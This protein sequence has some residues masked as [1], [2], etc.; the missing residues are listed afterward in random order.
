[1]FVK[2]NWNEYTNRSFNS[3]LLVLLVNSGEGTFWEKVTAGKMERSSVLSLYISALLS[4][5]CQRR[6]E[7]TKRRGGEGWLA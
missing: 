5:R 7:T 1:M 3:V 2:L 6:Q 4:W